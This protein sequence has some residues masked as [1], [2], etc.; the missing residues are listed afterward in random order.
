MSEEILEEMDPKYDCLRLENQVCFPLYASSRAV[1]N[2]YK[3]LLEKLDLTYTQYIVMLVMW[4]KKQVNVSELGNFLFLD[5]GTL[6]PVLK[7]LEQKKLIKRK[8]FKEDERVTIVTITEAG[9][10]LKDEA[11]DVPAEITNHIGLGQ[12]ET[13]TLYRL[14]YKV[15]GGFTQD[16]A[17]G[18]A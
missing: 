11:L 16:E 15:L 5:S 12:D 9:E 4:E 7:K 8:R 1:T 17:N 18:I 6:T 10:K 14:L 2:R 3:P 13:V